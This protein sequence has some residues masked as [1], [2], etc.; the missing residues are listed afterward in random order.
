LSEK[1]YHT[2]KGAII[3]REPYYI[4]SCDA[5]GW[6]GS[7]EKCGTDY[8]CGDD[9]DVYCPV[10]GAAGADCG[11]HAEHLERTQGQ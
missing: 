6:V 7:S 4:A 2:T 11:E 5:C 10:C 8:A 1:T 9:S 3:V